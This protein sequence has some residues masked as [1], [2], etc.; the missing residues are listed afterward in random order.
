MISGKNV[1]LPMHLS[2]VLYLSATLKTVDI[3]GELL[4]GCRQEYGSADLLVNPP[5][6]V[7]IDFSAK[8][9]Y[10]R[11]AD[12]DFTY[13]LFRALTVDFIRDKFPMENRG[14][15]CLS[16]TPTKIQG[17]LYGDTD[18]ESFSS[19]HRFDIIPLDLIS[20]IYESFTTLQQ[21]MM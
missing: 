11:F 18:T 19:T 3:N 1:R 14:T 6:R 7:G 13:S 12:K 9:L 17:L 16:K 20:S 2:V 5:K 10:Q 21:V 4:Q 15:G 8:D